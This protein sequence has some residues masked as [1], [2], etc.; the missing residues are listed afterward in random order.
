M[1]VE[2]ADADNAEGLA[3]MLNRESAC[4]GTRI[5]NHDGLLAVDFVRG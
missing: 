2:R 4:F 3:A 1:R 5:E